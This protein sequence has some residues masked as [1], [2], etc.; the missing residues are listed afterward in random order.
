MFWNKVELSEVDFSLP[1]VEFFNSEAGV[2]LML[3]FEEDTENG[4]FVLKFT[5]PEKWHPQVENYNRWQTKSVKFCNIRLTTGFGLTWLGRVGS[6]SMGEGSSTPTSTSRWPPPLIDLNR[7]LSSQ[8]I[9]WFVWRVGTTPFGWESR[10][11]GGTRA[12][13]WQKSQI[14]QH[15]N[16]N[17]LHS[18]QLDRFSGDSDYGF[19]IW[20]R[21]GFP[22][23][24]LAP[25]FISFLQE[26]LHWVDISMWEGNQDLFSHC[27]CS[28]LT[29]SWTSV[30]RTGTRYT[31]TTQ[32]PS[33]FQSSQLLAH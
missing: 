26:I 28:Q 24:L 29:M 1:S 32:F 12:V 10:V 3:D 18:P 23:H 15:Q 22:H 31:G 21:G 2:G 13:R 9:Q 30:W 8:L 16:E 11:W 17:I 33:I 5:F 6:T 25:A 27:F 4:N 14:D 19:V 20:R 7:F